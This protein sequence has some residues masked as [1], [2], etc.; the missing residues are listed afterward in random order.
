MFFQFG[1]RD[2]RPRRPLIVGKNDQGAWQCGPP[3]NV[4]PTY[5]GIE[6]LWLNRPLDL[7]PLA[8]SG[9]D[10]VLDDHVTVRPLQKLFDPE[11]AVGAARVGA[12]SRQAAVG[13][14]T[15]EPFERPNDREWARNPRGAGV[16]WNDRLGRPL[17]LSRVSA[18][19]CS[20]HRVRWL[21]RYAARLPL[22]VLTGYS[23]N[24]FLVSRNMA[25]R[26]C[27]ASNGWKAVKSSARSSLSPTSPGSRKRRKPLPAASD[28]KPLCVVRKTRVPENLDIDRRRHR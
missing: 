27:A 13:G 18:Y 5:Q 8:A 15:N 25:V 1:L 28:L 2:W 3:A 17:Q 12:F 10:E 14:R 6:K 4:A 16:G 20:G 11:D 26:F 9:F 23:V 22:H 24:W 19:T 21:S 7:P